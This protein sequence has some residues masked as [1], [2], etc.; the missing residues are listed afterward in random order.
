MPYTTRDLLTETFR[1]ITVLAAGESLQAQESDVGLQKLTRLFDN[2]NAERAGVY[3]NRLVSYTLTASLNPNTI[4]PSAAS[5]TVTQ[6]PV[7]IDAANLLLPDGTPTT[8]SGLA[9]RNAQWWAAL[10]YPALESIPSDL[11]YEPDWPNGNIYLYPIP[12]A[13][14]GL[15]LLTRIV[16]ADLALD[17]TV[18]LPPGYRDAVILTLGEMLAPSYPTAVPDPEGAAKSRSRI[19]ANTDELPMLTTTD[20]GIPFQGRANGRW[21]D[22]RSGIMRP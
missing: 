17:D 1:D 9:I 20:S 10:T 21:F 8:H 4:G 18:T 22:Y 13:A 11:H 5:F 2:W 3:A 19:Y 12:A 6:R 14:Y 7:K 16:L 15:E